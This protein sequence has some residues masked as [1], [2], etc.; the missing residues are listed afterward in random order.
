MTVVTTYA[1]NELVGGRFPETARKNQPRPLRSDLTDLGRSRRVACAS[2]GVEPP[3]SSQ[4][5]YAAAAAAWRFPRVL[6][7]LATSGQQQSL[8]SSVFGYPRV[9]I[10][11][12]DHDRCPISSEP[13]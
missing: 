13:R 7:L 10:S 9:I 3:G 6:L 1:R 2:A 11:W 8:L 12:S 5:S 4:N